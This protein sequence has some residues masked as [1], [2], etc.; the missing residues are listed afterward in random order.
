MHE[1]TAPTP[2]IPLTGRWQWLSTASSS[3]LVAAAFV[4]LL[5]LQ[6]LLIREGL[7]H[8]QNIAAD[9]EFVVKD[10]GEREQRTQ[11]M[12]MAA[13]N[14][15]VLLLRMLAQP[16]PLER[17]DDAR[18][19]EAEGLAFGRARDALRSTQLDAAGRHNLEA[20]LTGAVD[21]SQRQRLVVQHLLMGQ[22]DT[23]RADMDTHRVFALQ[24]DLVGALQRFGDSQHTLT[25]HAQERALHAHSQAR[26]VMLGMGAGI[27]LLG[28]VL[29]ATVTR[30]ISRAEGVLTRDKA[31]ADFAAK[32]DALTGLLNR[33]GFDD[34][35]SDW[36]QSPLDPA[37]VH[38]LM[39]IDLDKFKPVNDQAGH[40]A[41][42]ALLKRLAD[43][44]RNSTRPQD[45]VA[46]LGGDE[47][48]IVLHGM[49]LTAST[50][51]AE[52]V[53]QTV[54]DF[55]FDWQ[56]QH[57]QL[58][59]SIGIVAFDATA[60]QSD[61]STTLRLADEACYEAKHKGRN[62]VCSASV[63]ATTSN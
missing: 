19:F 56:G 10:I 12:Q 45:L 5:V 41:G 9:F 43:I 57:F 30:S 50:E 49:P 44:F 2:Q 15:I 3:R 36:R 7:A 42:D 37:S 46:R 1:F 53:R 62:R 33:R 25:L 63:S 17:E 32:H 51:V 61:W 18:A 29:G 47:F 20:V 14:R 24:R 58:G 55:T 11:Q 6:G 38:T 4:M 35:L 21:L 54:H 59:T 13:Q 52:R 39:L 34:A 16:D 27:F 8:L 26:S 40:A 22:D 31:R 48:A 28:L 60:P 23:A